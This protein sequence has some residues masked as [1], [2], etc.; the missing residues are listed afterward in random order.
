MPLIS[1]PVPRTLRTSSLETNKSKVIMNKIMTKIRITINMMEDTMIS[2]A[3]KVVKMSNKL[4]ELPTMMMISSALNLLLNLRLLAHLIVSLLVHHFGIIVC[5]RI[6]RQPPKATTTVWQY[7]S[8][9]RRI[10][11]RYGRHGRI[12]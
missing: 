1:K 7:A 5:N 8:L 4:V 3:P 6:Y 12:R 2:V 10:L 9:R 11:W